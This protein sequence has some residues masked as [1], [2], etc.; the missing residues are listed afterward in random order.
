MRLSELS[1][2]SIGSVLQR[3]WTADA[4]PAIAAGVVALTAFVLGGRPLWLW[5]VVAVIVAIACDVGLSRLRQHLREVDA[6]TPPRALPDRPAVDLSDRVRRWHELLSDDA[7]RAFVLF[8]YGTCVALVEEFED[9]A[10]VARE[11]LRQFG[12]AVAG[13]PS[14]DMRLYTLP[15]TGDFVVGGYHPNLLTY[16]PRQAVADAASPD[17]AAAFGGRDLRV[18]DSFAL[19]IIAVERRSP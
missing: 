19:E 12:P 17:L 1:P 10:A 8:S 7:V 9:P 4:P 5:V 14:A 2:E 16:V 11:L 18:L 6:R 3:N 13:T 15:E